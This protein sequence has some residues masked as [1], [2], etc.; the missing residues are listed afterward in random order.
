MEK[1]ITNRVTNYTKNFKRDLHEY[2]CKTFKEKKYNDDDLID[3]MIQESV[4]DVVNYI[5][6]YKNLEFS[7][8][9]FQ[10]RKRVKNIVPFHARCIARRANCE[11]CTRRRKGTSQFC[12]THIKGTPHGKINSENNEKEYNEVQITTQEIQGI[13]YYIDENSNVYDPIDIQQN[14]INPK[15]IAK[16]TH[17]NGEYKI[18]SLCK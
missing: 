14:K 2:I 3:K 1:R 8:Q 7:S 18:P 5:Y 4:H 6:N 13:I 15:V 17:E 12:G 11:Q 9:D 16:Y 10:K